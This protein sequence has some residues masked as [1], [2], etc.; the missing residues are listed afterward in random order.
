MCCKGKEI[1]ASDPLYKKTVDIMSSEDRLRVAQLLPK[2]KSKL[3]PSRQAFNELFDIFNKFINDYPND[4][5]C[6]SCQSAIRTFWDNSIK[7]WK[8]AKLI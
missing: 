5:G 6:T 3:N 7:H 1:K 8:A 2:I 4:K